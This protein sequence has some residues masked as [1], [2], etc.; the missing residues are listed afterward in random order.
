ME[1]TI[2]YLDAIARVGEDAWDRLFQRRDPFVRYAY[3]SALEQSNCVGAASGWQVSHLALKTSLQGEVVALM[4]L[5]IKS[6]SY[7]EYLFDWS[8]AEAYQHHGLDYYPKLVSAIPFTPVAGERLA[9]APDY[10]QYRAQI[11]EQVTQA[12]LTKARALKAQTVQ[13]FFYQ[14]QSHFA[15]LARENRWLVRRDVQFYWLNDNYA[16]FD[17]YLAAMTA[18]K[19]KNINKERARVFAAG[20]RFQ[21]LSGA[22]MNT[23]L[24]QQFCAFYR[25]TYAKRSGHYGYLNEAFFSCLGQ[26]MADD[27]LLLF[28]RQ[29]DRIVAAA[30]FFRDQHT[31]YGRYWGCEQEFDF[32][33]FETCYYQGIEY[34]ISRQLSGFNA[35]VQG[36]HKVARGFR[37]VFAY[38]AYQIMRPDFQAAIRDFLEQENL[39]LQ[40]YHRQMHS[41]LPFKK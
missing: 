20:I 7:G 10:Q 29:Q 36:E 28:A 24:W 6:H 16:D 19:R 1:F 15:A 12:L 13:C 34:C 22:E 26:T 37:P 33:H 23:G 21:W 4:P 25:A 32:L 11:A 2:D 18:R 30:L 39:Y 3:L 41:R 14:T 8:W 38:G 27:L 5:Y 31:L 9:I 40:D 35:G 17:D